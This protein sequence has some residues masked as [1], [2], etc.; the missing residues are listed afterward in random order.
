[1]GS[2]FSNRDDTTTK[3]E[4]VIFLRPVVVREASLDGAYKAYRSYLPDEKFLKDPNDAGPNP[5]LEPARAEAAK[6]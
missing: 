2:V 5:L 1:L 3:T 4:L 6:P